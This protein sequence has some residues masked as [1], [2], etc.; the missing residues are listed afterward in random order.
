MCDLKYVLRGLQR[1]VKH[2]GGVRCS[3]IFK[4][5]QGFILGLQTSEVDKS[6]NIGCKRQCFVGRYLC[7]M[8]GVIILTLSIFAT[9]VNKFKKKR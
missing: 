9:L 7:Y 1:H 4:A 3:Q 5:N 8:L 6:S 2:L